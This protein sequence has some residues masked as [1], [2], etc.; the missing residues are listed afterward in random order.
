M[1]RWMDGLSSLA[2]GQKPPS[3]S[4]YM[5]LSVVVACFVTASKERGREVS[6]P[7]NRVSF[8]PHLQ[9]HMP[10]LL[11]CFVRCKSLGQNYTQWRVD[12]IYKPKG[13]K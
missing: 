11:L 13:K 7:E 3:V 10:T 12:Y 2:V 4:C 1:N 5:D 6:Q 8:D 9:S